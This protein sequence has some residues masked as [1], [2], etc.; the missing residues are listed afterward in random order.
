MLNLVVFDFERHDEAGEAFSDGNS[1]S[2]NGKD[3]HLPNNLTL[4][5]SR[6]SLDAVDTSLVAEC[7]RA[8]VC[9]KRLNLPRLAE[10]IQLG[11]P[12]EQYH[13][14]SGSSWSASMFMGLVFLVYLWGRCLAEV[15]W[16][17]RRR[18]KLRQIKAE[19]NNRLPV[20]ELFCGNVNTNTTFQC[21]MGVVF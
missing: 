3:K 9:D 1:I 14:G 15:F 20:Y 4:I 2:V 10:I 21:N 6:W 17:R 5:S 11:Y 8:E 12:S 19:W 18:M 13:V 16:K 7:E